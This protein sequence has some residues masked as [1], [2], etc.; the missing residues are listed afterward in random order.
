[1][2]R[3]CIS[4][5]CQNQRIGNN[6][7][8]LQMFVLGMENASLQLKERESELME[9]NKL[10]RKR[11]NTLEEI[12]KM[13]EKKLKNFT[14]EKTLL[15]PLKTKIKIEEENNDYVDCMS[16]TLE[17]KEKDEDL[18]IYFKRVE[19]ADIDIKGQE[20]AR[21]TVVKENSLKEETEVHEYVE[22]GIDIFHRDEK[23]VDQFNRNWI[24]IESNF[25]LSHDIKTDAT[26]PHTATITKL[27]EVSMDLASEIT[28][29]LDNLSSES[30]VNI[31]SSDLNSSLGT[32]DKNFVSSTRLSTSSFNLRKKGRKAVK[33]TSIDNLMKRTKNKFI[34]DTTH[35]VNDVVEGKV[36]INEQV[37]PACYYRVS[38]NTPQLT[39]A[40]EKKLVNV[41]TKRIYC[42]ICSRRFA[43]KYALK[44]HRLIH[45]VG[46]RIG[47]VTSLDLVLLERRIQKVIERE[48]RTYG[49]K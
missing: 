18:E 41:D 45:T 44:N 13:L 9:Q 33:R 31:Y 43:S 32:F 20:H 24:K 46:D 7:R 25:V 23:D 28:P 11:I 1:M 26:E 40:L 35:T 17:K 10:L 22:D 21:D 4:Q 15:N 3:V 19:I 6:Y 27:K 38:G 34:L 42:D 16:T 36:I 29:A 39:A 8:V 14:V 2:D 49:A 48:T 5:N 47:A 30:T 12:N 37:K